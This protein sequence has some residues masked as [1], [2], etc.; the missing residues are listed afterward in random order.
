MSATLT[1]VKPGSGAICFRWAGKTIDE[2]DMRL[3]TIAAAVSGLLAASLGSHAPAVAQSNPEARGE[4]IAQRL[5]ARCHAIGREDA[6]AM[7]LA[8]PFRDLPKRYPVDHL[9]EALAEGIVTGHPAMPQFTFTP[10]EIGAL[11]S[12][13]SSLAPQRK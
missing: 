8:P 5:C 2:A 10:R 7:G 9:A 13:I 1:L 12:Y 3:M 11:L 6:S 4:A